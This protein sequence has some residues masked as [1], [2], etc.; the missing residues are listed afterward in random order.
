MY[1]INFSLLNVLLIKKIYCRA[2][3]FVLCMLTFC[4]AK[5]SDDCQ[6]SFEY[7]NIL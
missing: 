1:Y 6:Y 3:F 4:M 7:T 5:K 2:V